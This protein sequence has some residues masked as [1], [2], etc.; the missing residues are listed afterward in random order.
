MERERKTKHYWIK[1]L[2][3]VFLILVTL[4]IAFALLYY[5]EYLKYELFCCR[6]IL[7]NTVVYPDGERVWDSVG[8][9]CFC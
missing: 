1:V 5:T 8:T 7:E 6:C 3:I 9:D 4:S 2:V